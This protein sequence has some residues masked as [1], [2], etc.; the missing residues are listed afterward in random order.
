MKVEI[1]DLVN[2]EK[3]DETYVLAMEKDGVLNIEKTIVLEGIGFDIWTIL[4]SEKKCTVQ[5]LVS[6]ICNEYDGDADV[7]EK[8]ILE[9]LDDLKKLGAIDVHEKN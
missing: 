4:K 2:E 8:D 6:K 3:I 5:D 1:S 9:F 7:I